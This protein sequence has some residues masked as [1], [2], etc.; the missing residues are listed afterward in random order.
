MDEKD[1]P[2]TEQQ[3]QQIKGI[4]DRLRQLDQ[5]RGEDS[6]KILDARTALRIIEY[7]ESAVRWYQNK[8][9]QR[10]GYIDHAKTAVTPSTNTATIKEISAQAPIADVPQDGKEQ[11]LMEIENLLIELNLADRPRSR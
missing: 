3:A 5:G 8:L 1:A 11:K 2:L 10:S 6:P 4:L 9:E 7:Y